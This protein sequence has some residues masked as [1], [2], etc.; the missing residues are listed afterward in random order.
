MTLRLPRLPSSQPS[1]SKFQVWWQ[2]VCQSIET[3]EERQDE[4]AG[5][6]AAAV[7]AIQAAQDAAD[8]A[9]A[10]A[11]AANTA[12]DAA[13]DTAVAITEA[14][15]LGNSF[16]VGATVGALDAGASATITISPHTRRYPQPDG[17]NVDVSVSG[18]SVTSLA[19]STAFY[20][21]YDDPTRAGGAVTYLATT[22]ADTAVQTGDRHV[23]GGAT[24]P[25]MGAGPTS[26]DVVKG[27]GAG[28][29]SS[30]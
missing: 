8:A 6:L 7:A 24:T 12:A 18:G 16:P 13:Q 10:A 22:S 14:S 4:A 21:Y 27:R 28:D 29:V 15:A 23:V 26:G 25:A 19:Y 9:N 2:T 20:V 1:W 5:A 11:V 17:T 30:I 3:Q